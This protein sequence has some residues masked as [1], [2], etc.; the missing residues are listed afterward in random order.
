[1][2]CEV[3]LSWTCTLVSIR[4]LRDE[5]GVE[6][7]GLPVVVTRHQH[8]SYQSVSGVG[9][10]DGDLIRLCD[11]YPELAHDLRSLQLRPNTNGPRC[12]VL[13]LVT[14]PRSDSKRVDPR[15]TNG[16]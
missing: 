5:P 3:S 16:T 6:T 10:L 7:L 14:D 13:V 2:G 4:Q 8:R 11:L 1:M 9:L 15:S 12:S